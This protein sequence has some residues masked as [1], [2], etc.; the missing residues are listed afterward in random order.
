MNKEFIN[1]I[2]IILSQ[3]EIDDRV[4][5]LIKLYFLGKLKSRDLTPEQLKSQINILCSR[6]LNVE[7]SSNNIVVAYSGKANVLTINKQLFAEG[8]SDEVILPV[9]MKFEEALNQSN[10]RPYANHIEDFIRAGRIAKANSIPISDRLH[11]LYE[12]AEYCYGDTEYKIDKL[13]DDGSWQATCSKYNDALNTMIISGESHRKDLLNGVNL[14][15][16]EVFTSEAIGH[17]DFE[18]PFKN[19][20]YQ[21]KAAR[22]LGC[23]D[24]INSTTGQ[25][26]T[27]EID[28]LIRNIK[29]FTGCTREMVEEAKLDTYIGDSR[30]STALQSTIQD[31]P[32]KVSE[33]F[34][35][36][37]VK[38]VLDRKPNYDARIKHLIIPFFIRSQKIYNWNIDEFQ[39]RLNEL[40]LKI[41]TIVF[42]DLESI[43]TMGD[44]ARDKIRLNSRIFFDRNRKNSLACSRNSCP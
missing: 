39:E 33:E 28:G 44:T 10:R 25:H 32:I 18:G 11:K 2:N 19:E 6:I 17:P 1:Q 21:K 27:V 42:E 34:I 15:H 30:I 12:M 41:D 13:I 22:V 29:L 4:K 36:S 26:D 23:M 7:F 9:F 14:F 35:V 16:Y 43:T 40:D 24:Y 31:S 20:E 5:P 38:A 8:K 37:K 3:Q